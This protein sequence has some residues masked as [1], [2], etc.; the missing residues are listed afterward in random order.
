MVPGC[1][2]RWVISPEA[3]ASGLGLKFLLLKLISFCMLLLEPWKSFLSK[4]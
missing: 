2:G 3:Q 4:P 1:D